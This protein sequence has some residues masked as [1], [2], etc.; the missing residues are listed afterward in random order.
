MANLTVAFG[1][2]L[3]AFG[4]GSYYFTGMAS[5]SALIPSAFGVVLAALGLLARKDNLRMHAMHAAA[6]VALLGFL[7]G[8]FMAV[9][10]LGELLSTGRV[11]R[12][13][14][15]GHQSDAT[16]AV[17]CQLILAA[18]CLVFVGL[19]VNSFI[20]ARRARKAR[21]APGSVA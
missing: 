13:H 3:T 19:C 20:Q 15:D 21:E 8:A 4:L 11:L 16:V 2:L 12:T 17:V 14:A 7:G 5:Y 18:A 6:A 9:P 1:L 10:K